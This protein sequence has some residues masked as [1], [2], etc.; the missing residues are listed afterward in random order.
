MFFNDYN[1]LFQLIMLNIN[2]NLN[3]KVFEEEQIYL[4]DENSSDILMSF[5]SVNP[6]SDFQNYLK[7]TQSNPNIIEYLNLLN[8]SYFENHSYS[9]DIM[10]SQKLNT[11]I[12]N[13]FV[14]FNNNF[15]VN[16]ALAELKIMWIILLSYNHFNNPT[17]K[18]KSRI[19]K[20][21]EHCVKTHSLDLVT[22]T[23]NFK[24]FYFLDLL[25]NTE[26][27]SLLKKT[28]SLY[29][30]DVFN[31]HSNALPN[32][33]FEFD[34]NSNDLKI[35]NKRND[36]INYLWK[37]FINSIVNKLNYKL[38]EYCNEL[39]STNNERKIFCSYTCKNRKSSADSYE[40]SKKRNL[41]KL[42]SVPGFSNNNKPYKIITE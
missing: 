12:E 3:L 37:E 15:V 32:I 10:F 38:C 40:R 41:I 8:F 39:F 29:V 42:N 35:K 5:Y 19:L 36:C 31:N 13:N 2:D 16:D 26:N 6:K 1:Y 20:I 25:S 30:K 17:K 33:K 34:I 22:S 9:L 4:Y 7:L 27:D 24:S 28:M 14:L 11:Y 18:T 23:K 21:L